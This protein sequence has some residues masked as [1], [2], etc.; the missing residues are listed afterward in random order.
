M[1]VRRVLERHHR[2]ADRY[3]FTGSHIARRLLD[4][5]GLEH[6][7]VEVTEK[8]DHYDPESRAVRLLP[9]NAEGRSLT[10]ITVAAHEVGH[11][12][13]HDDAYAPLML[14]TSMVTWLAPLERVGMVMMVLGPVVVALTR[15]PHAGLI[16]ILGGLLVMG[17]STAVHLVTLPTELDAS[18]GKALPMLFRNDLVLPEDRPAARKILLAAALTYVAASL[19]ALLNVARWWAVL[20][21]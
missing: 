3:A 2:P 11:A 12:L 4:A 13:Q 10:A 20:R 19:M 9:A 21:R 7:T 15:I 8:G 18:F 17:G 16:S 1:W 5:H 14:R 6:V